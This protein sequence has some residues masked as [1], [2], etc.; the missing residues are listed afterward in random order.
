M[1]F[2]FSKTRGFSNYSW[3]SC[4]ITAITFA[5]NVIYQTGLNKKIRATS[6]NWF[7][8]PNSWYVFSKH[9]TK[10]SLYVFENPFI[11]LLVLIIIGDF[12]YYLSHRIFH[13]VNV[14]WAFH[15]T[16]HTIT[17]FNVLNGLRSP[18]NIILPKSIGYSLFLPPLFLGY[19]LN[20][21][22]NMIIVL[23]IY[24]TWTHTSFFKNLGWLE[25]ILVTPSH[26]RVHHCITENS[27]RCG[28]NFG[29][30]LIIWDKMFG[31]F[32]GESNEKHIYGV[33]G[34]N[35]NDQLIPCLFFIHKKIFLDL[36][37]SRSVKTVFKALFW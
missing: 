3:K 22:S 1:E 17:K 13:K 8:I 27:S 29:G 32:K 28:A 9:I 26:H 19:T 20:E 34:F 21:L 2:F 16:H 31:T 33:S 14:L 37:R 12:I 18:L 36:V 6:F 30:L 25:Y 7:E 35:Q 5:I 24:G 15:F 10:N 4:Y 23:G 11:K